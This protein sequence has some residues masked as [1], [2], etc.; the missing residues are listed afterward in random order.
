MNLNMNSLH[1]K[2]GTHIS[3]IRN[4]IPL[5]KDFNNLFI[6]FP[7]HIFFVEEKKQ[8]PQSLLVIRNS[9]KK[10]NESKCQTLK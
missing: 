5:K 1:Q 4:S 3:I 8:K 6:I 2:K 7:L 10:Q 9:Y